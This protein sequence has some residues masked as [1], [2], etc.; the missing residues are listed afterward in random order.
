MLYI[1]I[2]LTREDEN[3]QDQLPA[4]HLLAHS[5]SYRAIP[6]QDPSH[7]PIVWHRTGGG[8]GIKMLIG[9]VQALR[10]S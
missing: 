7:S 9:T 8:G 5:Q 4:K 6:T 2:I 1:I 10:T 3:S